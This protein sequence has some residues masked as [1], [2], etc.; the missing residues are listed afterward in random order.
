MARR[1]LV[2]LESGKFSEFLRH[3]TKIPA[4]VHYIDDKYKDWLP[5]KKNAF[6]RSANVAKNVG[7]DLEVKANGPRGIRFNVIGR[8]LS[9]GVRWTGPTV[10]VVGIVG[11]A[12]RGDAE[13][14]IRENS[15]LQITGGDLAESI[16]DGIAPDE[17]I[18]DLIRQ[19]ER[20]VD[21]VWNETLY[22]QRT[23]RD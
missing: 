7:V 10:V 1:K 3:K 6:I 22:P 19:R 16:V 4:G 15:F 12:A 11:G 13:E 17:A 21:D 2:Q 20:E 14:T 5:D 23:N 9:F 18:H 8:G